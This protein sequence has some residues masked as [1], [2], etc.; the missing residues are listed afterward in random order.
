[1]AK[2][3]VVVTV[4]RTIRRYGSTYSPSKLLSSYAKTLLVFKRQTT[5]KTRLI[6]SGKQIEKTTNMYNQ[7]ESI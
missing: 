2:L 6:Y 7:F 3:P 4:C 1:M 5:Q